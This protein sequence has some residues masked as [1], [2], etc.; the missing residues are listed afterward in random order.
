MHVRIQQILR[1]KTDSEIIRNRA[2]QTDIQLPA[3]LLI[4][5]WHTVVPHLRKP[6]AEN[7]VGN[8]T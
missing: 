8:R 2:T 5:I 4:D 6:L 7:V 1:R 3:R